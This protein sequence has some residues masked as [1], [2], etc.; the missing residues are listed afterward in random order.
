MP[1]I[2]STMQPIKVVL[3]SFPTQSHVCEGLVDLMEQCNLPIG[4][5]SIIDLT[6]VMRLSEYDTERV[7]HRNG[8][9]VDLQRIVVGHDNFVEV[10]KKCVDYAATMVDGTTKV[11]F[12]T[13]PDGT[14]ADVVCQAVAARL[15]TAV[16]NIDLPESIAGQHLTF[17]CRHS[18]VDR[19]HSYELHVMFAEISSWLN[20]SSFA[21]RGET[22]NR[23]GIDTCWPIEARRVL[24]FDSSVIDG[25]LT[26]V[27]VGDLTDEEVLFNKLSTKCAVH[28]Q[29]LETGLQENDHHLAAIFDWN[30][31]GD[32]ERLVQL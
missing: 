30:G 16:V 5:C 20:G 23:F 8:H 9:R 2:L 32:Q 29:Q 18:R 10:V 13:D 21:R 19:L 4:D 24:L 3:I 7:Q 31:T 14:V 25:D 17:Q 27:I 22:E 1:A 28:L 26:E 6:N 15:N 11:M 12:V